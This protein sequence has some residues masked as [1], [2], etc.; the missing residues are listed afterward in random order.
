MEYSLGMAHGSS[1]PGA[2]PTVRADG[3]DMRFTYQTPRTDVIYQPEWS[4]DL[5]SWSADGFT[6]TSDGG[7]TMASIT[8]GA[9]SRMFLRLRVILH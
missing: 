3:G 2:L 5:V 8:A 9:G 7:H 1:D 4:D 6:V